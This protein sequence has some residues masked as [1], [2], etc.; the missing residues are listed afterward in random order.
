VVEVSE[1]V[2]MVD[3][4]LATSIQSLTMVFAVAVTFALPLLLSFLCFPL[5][6]LFF[7]FF[8]RDGNELLRWWCCCCWWWCRRETL[9]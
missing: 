8:F 4:D 1:S 7:P 9:W 2:E 5:P 3:V 6:F